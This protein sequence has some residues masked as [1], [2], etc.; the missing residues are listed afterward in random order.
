L[1]GQTQQFASVANSRATDLESWRSG[2]SV[3][4]PE[5][6]IEDELTEEEKAFEASKPAVVQDKLRMM[7]SSFS[8]VTKGESDEVTIGF[9]QALVMYASP[10]L[11]SEFEHARLSGYQQIQK[12]I[13]CARS[14]TKFLE[15]GQPHSRTYSSPLTDNS[16][17]GPGVNTHK[18]WQDWI[19][20]E[21]RRRLIWMMYI[22]DTLSIIETGGEAHLRPSEVS[23]IPLP[24]PDTIWQAKSSDAWS[25]ALMG[26]CPTTL[27]VA[28]TDHFQSPNGGFMASTGFESSSHLNSLLLRNDYGSFGRL[29]MVRR[30][31]WV[32]FVTV[33]TGTHTSINDRSLLCFEA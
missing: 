9:L 20:L 27:R 21:T 1:A 24:V 7:Q 17:L 26:Y 31:D 10:L 6:A 28:L 33:L 2:A 29:I 15:S 19:T 11:L 18:R 4:D 16:F 23:E 14:Y 32:F 13:Y 30:S 3:I 8:Q 22:F 12:V 5:A 25:L